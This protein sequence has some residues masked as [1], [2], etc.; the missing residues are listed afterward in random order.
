MKNWF[1]RYIHAN[2]HSTLD[3]LLRH[4]KLE[5]SLSGNEFW[6]RSNRSSLIVIGV[7]SEAWS[8]QERNYR[9]A[10]RLGMRRLI[11]HD[12]PGQITERL[13]MV[14]TSLDDLFPED[15]LSINV[16]TGGMDESELIAGWMWAWIARVTGSPIH[17][18]RSGALTREFPFWLGRKENRSLPRI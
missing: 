11:R 4:C 1:F 13:H 18:Q 12:S 17:E 6:L 3:L 5:G 16:V 14:W 10:I 15:F 2:Q 7:E 8:Y 9:S